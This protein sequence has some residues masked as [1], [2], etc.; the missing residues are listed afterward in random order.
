M[1]SA[2]VGRPAVIFDTI[3][4]KRSFPASWRRIVRRLLRQLF[5]VDPILSLIGVNIYD[6]RRL[7]VNNVGS[8]RE[9]SSELPF[10]RYSRAKTLRRTFSALQSGFLLWSLPFGAVSIYSM[11]SHSKSHTVIVPCKIVSYYLPLRATNDNDGGHAQD[12]FALRKALRSQICSKEDERNERNVSQDI[13]SYTDR[14]KNILIIPVRWEKNILQN[15][16]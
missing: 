5:A 7:L 6:G 3:I 16:F 15:A 11:F 2:S 13:R 12:T 4:V 8:A 9:S 10:G 1:S 14:E